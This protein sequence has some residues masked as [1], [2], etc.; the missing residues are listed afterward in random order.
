VQQVRELAEWVG[1]ETRNKYQILDENKSVVG[2]AA[3]QQ[4]GVA[5]FLL[6]QTLGHWRK[7]DIYFFNPARELVWV[8]HHP[9]RWILERIELRSKDGQMIGAIQRRFAL[10][11]RRFH[12]ENERGHV[13]LEVASPI[14]KIWTYTFMARG[15]AVAQVQ[16]KWS[17]IF[18]EVFTDRDNFLVEYSDASLTEQ[19][20][21]LI[22]AAAVFVDL[23][24]F[25]RKQ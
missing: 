17:G 4:K 12:I 5:G 22:L 19:D 10:L 1:L 15:R 16:K 6:R 18:S 2:Y 20:R 14:W 11:S 3:E 24:F 7:F 13:I 25:E 8:A 9:F 21:Q 23:S